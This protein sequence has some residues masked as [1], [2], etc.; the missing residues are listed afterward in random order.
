M[1]KFHPS[2]SSAR[3]LTDDILNDPADDKDIMKIRSAPFESRLADLKDKLSILKMER[4]HGPKAV[5]SDHDLTA[6][7][8]KSGCSRGGSETD[9]QWSHGFHSNALTCEPLPPF[10]TSSLSCQYSQSGIQRL[11]NV[12]VRKSLSSGR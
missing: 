8:S 6:N 3:A 7:A 11:T 2:Y 5:Q 4:P 12:L 10:H 1:A 9:R